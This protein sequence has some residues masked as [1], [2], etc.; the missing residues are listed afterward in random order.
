[1]L[2]KKLCLS[3]AVVSLCLMNASMLFAYDLP[4]VNLG[5]T[6]YYDAVPP[7]G[8]GL[9]FTQYFHYIE[10]RNF[11]GNKG[12]DLLPRSAKEDLKGFVSMTQIIY[13]APAK[14]FLN[15]R[16]GIDVALPVVFTDLDY[17][18]SGPFPENNSD[19]IGDLLVGPFLQWD[20]VSKKDGSPL[21][22]HRV[23]F[24]L[25]FPTGR[26][27]RNK[28]INP[29]SNFFSFNPYWSSTWWI[30]PRWTTSLRLH[31]LWNAKN[32]Q[33][34]RSFGD[35]RHTQAGQAIHLNYTM[36][37]AVI[38]GKLYLG[39]NGYYLKQ[40]TDTEVN[41][42]DVSG[43]REQVFAIG[44][45]GLW[46]ITKTLHM[47]FNTYFESYARNRPEGF[48]STVRFVYKF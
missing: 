30:M 33:P 24:Q 41:G 32:Q 35:V 14:P 16:P 18:S 44:P 47:F 31:Y 7:N 13:T 4:N 25:L 10:S 9:Y 37:Y 29:G 43:R 48:R 21:M 8:P 39:I 12:H 17:R 5:F 2:L 42:H 34:N 23:E 15:A 46:S 27:S 40:F 6:S 3:V 20:P 19:G 22:A 38:P 26:Y 36:D 28:E 45:G 11:T 1:M